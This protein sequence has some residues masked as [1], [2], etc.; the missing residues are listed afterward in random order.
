MDP[1]TLRADFPILDREIHGHPLAYLDNAASSQKPVAVIEAID[2]F[3][4]AH[5]ANIHR[6]VHTLSEEATVAYEAAR[7]KVAAFINAPDRRGVIFTRNATEAINLVAYAWGR[8]NV[9]PGDRVVVTEM[10]HHSNIVPWQMLTQEVGADLVTFATTD[11]GR[12]DLDDLDRALDGPVK[13]LAFSHV[14]NVL[15]TVNPAR[16]ITARAHAAGAQV[17]IDAA[18]S[19]PHLPVDVQAL[20]CDFLAF[21][22]HKMC[23]P[24]GVGA[25]YGRPEILEAMP[26]FMGG[27]GMIRRVTCE[28][29]A[30]ASLPAKFEAGTPAIAEAVGLGAAVDYLS[31]VGMAAIWAHER[32]LAAYALERLAELDAENSCMRVLGPPAGERCGLVSFTVAGIHPHDLAQVLDWEGVAIRAGH[33][34]A[35]PLHQ[36]CGLTASARASFYLY[37]TRDE[38]DRLIVGIRKAQDM[39]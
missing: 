12:L 38:I 25:L 37:N 14:S 17:L 10:E 20:D 21:S 5:Y 1:N 22:G 35:Q 24:S 13:L 30:W 7:D 16:E 31:D 29:S 28:E 19:V 11:E 3:Y 2:R 23:G 33:H 6:G 27:G 4:R 32:E 26:P 9:G 39:F 36:R 34:C 18:Q 15:G 8:T